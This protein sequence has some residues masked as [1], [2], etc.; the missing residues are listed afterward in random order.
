MSKHHVILLWG[1]TLALW[2]NTSLAT[3]DPA[4]TAAVATTTATTAATPFSNEAILSDPIFEAS[5]DLSDLK[6]QCLAQEQI[7]CLTLAMFFEGQKKFPQDQYWYKQACNLNNAAACHRLA[8]QLAGGIGLTQPDLTRALKFQRQACELKHEQACTHA[9]LAYYQGHGV[10]VNLK[11]ALEFFTK[12]STLNSPQGSLFTGLFYQKGLGVNADQAQALNYF[13]QACD[14]KYGAGCFE[15]ANLLS[16]S[17]DPETHTAETNTAEATTTTTTTASTTDTPSTVTKDFAA[18]TALLEKGCELN[19]AES[20]L[21]LGQQYL[22]GLGK[23]QDTT[24]AQQLFTKACDLKSTKACA[25]A[26]SLKE[27]N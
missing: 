6:K 27:Q 10:E 8:L 20:C 26:A 7:S 16:G 3:T 5:K 19:H 21:A 9:G 13:K 23:P 18:A 17:I 25:Y 15:A 14:L 24:Q 4:S 1:L 2:S 11:Q 22:H 12:A